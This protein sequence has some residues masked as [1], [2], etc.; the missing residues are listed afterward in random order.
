M[1]EP[2]LNSSLAKPQSTPHTTPCNSISTTTSPSPSSALQS[3]NTDNSRPL[4]YED[5]VKRATRIR[6]LFDKLDYDHS[7]YLDAEKIKRRFYELA[8]KT[9]IPSKHGTN[10]NKP[11]SPGD[12]QLNRYAL[13]LLHRC[14]ESKDGLVDFY[15]FEKFVSDKENELWELFKVSYIS[16]CVVLYQVAKRNIYILNH[17]LTDLFIYL[18]IYFFVPLIGCSKLIQQKIIYYNHQ[19]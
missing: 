8:G 6:A 17:P 1:A 16:I 5:P 13:D 18:F 4:P 12:I 7:G 11:K 2:P 15:E 3:S 19:N 9:Y 10:G 14:D